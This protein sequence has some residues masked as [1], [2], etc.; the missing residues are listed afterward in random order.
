MYRIFCESYRAYIDEV[1]GVRA[2]NSQCLQLLA[3]ETFFVKE[4]AQC[5]EKYKQANNLLNYLYLNEKHSPGISSLLW[6]MD[7]RGIKPEPA[8]IKEAEALAEQVKLIK[9]FVKLAYWQ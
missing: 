2:L 6:S 7:S 8:E 3:D 9:S 4:K 5:T 1:D